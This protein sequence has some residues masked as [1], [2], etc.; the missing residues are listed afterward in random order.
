MY[1]RKPF[2][3]AQSLAT[4]GTGW[5]FIAWQ[6]ALAERRIPSG[7]V[8]ISHREIDEKTEG[9]MLK[10]VLRSNL[11]LGAVSICNEN[12]GLG[13]HIAIDMGAAYLVLGTDVP[14]VLDNRRKVGWAVEGFSEVDGKKH[15]IIWG[16]LT[17]NDG[18]AM[19]VIG[20]WL[21]RNQIP[22]TAV[23]FAALSDQAKQRY[24]WQIAK[25]PEQKYGAGVDSTGQ[26]NVNLVEGEEE[27]LA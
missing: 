18:R 9:A 3:E 17:K 5:A 15:A 27:G 10:R 2:P 12:D 4:F 24:I 19:K 23:V 6:E 16:V 21:G 14:G 11:K 8:L 22:T 7:L 1:P 13:S 20:D 26:A 25:Q